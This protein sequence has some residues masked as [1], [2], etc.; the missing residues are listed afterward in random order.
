MSG[1]AARDDLD[2]LAREA[3]ALI[4]AAVADGQAPFHM[5]TVATTD[6][7]GAPRLRTVVLRAADA[8]AGT[9]RFHTDLRSAK[10][11]ELARDPRLAMH[12]YDPTRR[13]QVQLAGRATMATIDAAAGRSAWETARPASRAAYGV[14]PGPGAPIAAGGDYRLPTT[15]AEIG[16]G[17]I[18]FAAVTVMAERLDW[19]SLDATG[20]RRAH[21]LR[22]GAGWRGGWLVP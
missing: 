18:H 7:E 13:V 1:L 19:L 4:T 12:F 8:A 16:A 15:E 6:G 11:S 9:V 3:W 10:V 22:A 21:F 20:H 14:M 2:A 17:A 5:P